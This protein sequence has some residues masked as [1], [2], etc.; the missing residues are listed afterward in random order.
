MPERLGALDDHR[1]HAQVGLR[2]DG[3]SEQS[4]ERVLAAPGWT[5]LRARRDRDGER[6][7]I[8]LKDLSD[9]AAEVEVEEAT[10]ETGQRRLALT[11][12]GWRGSGLV[13]DE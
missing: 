3:R 4:D 8:A 2:G 6:G 10:H 12:C 5:L 13:A 11:A 1:R 7:E 9:Q